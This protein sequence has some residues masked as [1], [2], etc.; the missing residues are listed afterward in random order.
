VLLASAGLS[1]ARASAASPVYPGLLA[2]TVQ[3]LS[4]KRIATPA[5]TLCH[6]TL[7]GGR[8]TVVSFF[9]TSLQGF[10]LRGTD[11]ASLDAALRTDLGE[12]W[13]SDGDEISDIEELVAG[14]DPNDGPGPVEP[15]PVPEHGC[16]LTGV[17]T[18][19]GGSAR[20]AWTLLLVAAGLSRRRRR[21]ADAFARDASP[22]NVESPPGARSYRHP[23]GAGQRRGRPAGG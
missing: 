5:C 7:A 4:G 13:D 18:G 21:A 6:A 15:R 17:D 23:R 3:S 14:S 22:S 16:S 9:G 19:A 2:S 10:G 8:G 11:P 20:V 12:N 1:W